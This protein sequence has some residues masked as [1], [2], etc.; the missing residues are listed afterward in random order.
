VPSAADEI[1]AAIDAAGGAIRFDEF[2]R[3]ALYGSHGFYGATG[4]R[5]G[6]RGDFITSPEVGPLFGAVVARFIDAEWARLGRPD[7]FTFVEAG[8]GPGTLARSVLAARPGCADALHYIAVEVSEAQ[9][10]AHPP[11]VESAATLPERVS[12]GVIFA[13]EVLD[14]LPFRLAVYDGEWREALVSTGAAGSFVEVLGDLPP[15]DRVAL[16]VTARHGSRVPVQDAAADWV[17]SALA[18]V[19]EG[20]VAAIDYASTTQQLAQRPYREWLRTYRRHER[21][22]HYLRSPGTQD[23]TAD[24]AVDQLPRA[25]SAT[26]QADWLRRWGIDALVEEGKRFWRER[27]SAPD[28]AALRM[29]SRIGE[30]EALLDA[31]GLGA[32]VVLEWASPADISSPGR[33]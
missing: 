26:T 18:C 21:G 16:P 25:A 13:N 23:I 24:V 15:A 5:A 32:F 7:P 3:L 27:A 30:A 22:E 28:L 8:A 19:G 20:C 6:R 11:D 14:N 4:G 17:T 9:R 1:R 33:N 29:R 10:E 31:S 2:M 12:S